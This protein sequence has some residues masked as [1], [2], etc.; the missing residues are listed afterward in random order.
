MELFGK[1]VL[2]KEATQKLNLNGQPELT[3]NH[4][5]SRINLSAE[6]LKKLD[7][8]NGTVGFGYDPNKTLSESVAF[9][10]IAEDGCKIGNAGT[11]GNKFHVDRLKNAFPEAS[12]ANRFKLLVDVDNPMTH[13]DKLLYPISFVE[14]LPELT[15]NRSKKDSEEVEQV[16]EAL[17]T[18]DAPIQFGSIPAPVITQVSNHFEEEEE[19]VN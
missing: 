9:I 18:E 10:Y 8:A 6:L 4:S 12:A 13:N 14:V 1:V 15:R 7:C 17:T 11:I 19:E 16:A 3:I 2:K 5:S